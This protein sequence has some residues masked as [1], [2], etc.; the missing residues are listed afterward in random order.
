[1]SETISRMQ[2]L[3]IMSTPTKEK[4]RDSKDCKDRPI[5]ASIALRFLREDEYWIDLTEHGE[6]LTNGYAIQTV[7]FN[8]K[9]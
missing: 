9:I 3:D 4:R 7:Y 5:A 8:T 2:R 6:L 1:M